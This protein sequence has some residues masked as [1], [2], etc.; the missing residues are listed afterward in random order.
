MTRSLPVPFFLLFLLLWAAERALYTQ[1]LGFSAASPCCPGRS[2]P[3]CPDLRLRPGVQ[4]L[5]RQ[6]VRG[7]GQASAPD[8][9][10]AV[11]ERRSEAWSPPPPTGSKSLGRSD[12]PHSSP[13]S[14]C[15]G[16]GRG[17]ASTPGRRR[18]RLGRCLHRGRRPAWG[19]RPAVRLNRTSEAKLPFPRWARRFVLK[20]ET[21]TLESK[22]WGGWAFTHLFYKQV[23]GLL[24]S[25]KAAKSSPPP[26]HG[27]SGKTNGKQ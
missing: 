8:A 1:M 10:D 26:P 14:S 24:Q 27:K 18:R 22:G 16:S 20:C 11:A 13:R 23:V 6:H 4:A 19:W 3:G 2:A 25:G 15:A 7:K 5:G 12:T 9:P 21:P 17:Q